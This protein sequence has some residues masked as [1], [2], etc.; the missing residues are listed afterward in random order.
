MFDVHLLKWV[1]RSVMI[2]SELPHDTRR[3]MLSL[4]SVNLILL[5]LF[6]CQGFVPTGENRSHFFPGDVYADD[7]SAPRFSIMAESDTATTHVAQPR[8]VKTMPDPDPLR[9]YQFARH[10]FQKGYWQQAITEFQRFCFLNPLHPL[11][12]EAML[13]AGKCYEL[14]GRYPEAITRYRTLAFDYPNSPAGE[15]ALY[16]VGVAFYRAGEFEKARL[17][18]ED[19]L[20]KRPATPWKLQARYR[21]AWASL[22]LHEF[23]VAREQFSALATGENPYHE[24]AEAI[25]KGIDNIIGLPHK[26]PLLAG[27]LSGV[28]PGAGQ[29]YSGEAK[30]ALLAFAV[31]AA[32][33]AA[34]YEAFH[35]EVYVAGG[36]VSVVALTF[37]SGNI[38]GALN[39][40]HHANQDALSAHLRPYRN[41]YEW[42]TETLSFSPQ[43]GINR[44]GSIK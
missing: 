31:N 40:A 38:Y 9:G 34:T 27:V 44:L 24:P 32:L 36:I 20:Q 37:Y 4:R 5:C 3:W 7:Y 12:P 43:S 16:R 15:E 30:N 2:P 25:E 33:I 19:F 6:I 8:A 17:A 41:Q 22:H 42:I 18:L 35:K 29:L 14:D 13:E 26:S 10:L 11:V 28:L 21:I 23:T 1:H 39:S